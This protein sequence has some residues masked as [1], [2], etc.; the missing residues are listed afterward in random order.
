MHKR[1]RLTPLY[2]RAIALSNNYI[3]KAYAVNP[4]IRKHIDDYALASEIIEG[5]HA[6]G[7]PRPTV[8]GVIR[9]HPTTLATVKAILSRPPS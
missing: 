9:S 2:E 8:L 5:S 1:A 4:M 6:K 7:L 3:A